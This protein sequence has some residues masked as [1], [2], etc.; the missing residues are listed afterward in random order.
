MALGRGNTF[1]TSSGAESRVISWLLQCDCFRSD[2]SRAGGYV[3]SNDRARSY[4]R[5]CANMQRLATARRN[6]SA[7]ADEH[8]LADDNAI[9]RSGL[10]GARGDRYA[11]PNGHF[12]A[13]RTIGMDH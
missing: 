12:P 9:C 5:V 4:L 6:V 11:V 2:H 10:L 7:G 1:E 13:D 3:A 8:R